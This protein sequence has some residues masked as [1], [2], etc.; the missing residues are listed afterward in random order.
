MS[1]HNIIDKRIQFDK[2][3]N[4]EDKER[5]NLFDKVF[6]SSLYPAV[7]KEL[8]SLRR[9]GITGDTLVNKLSD[10]YFQYNLKTLLEQQNKSVQEQI[11]TRLICSESLI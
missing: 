1:N 8:N 2:V 7:M 11:I 5:I 4:I 6:R 3:E 10:I 9:I